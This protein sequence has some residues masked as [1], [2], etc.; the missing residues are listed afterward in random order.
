MS[1]RASALVRRWVALYTRGLTPDVREA[2][3]EEIEADL[4]SQTEDQ[5]RSGALSG[6]GSTAI[7]SRLVRGLWADITW[8]L[9]QRRTPPQPAPARSH[10]LGSV[11]A[12]TCAIAGGAGLFAISILFILFAS[13]DGPPWAFLRD[14]PAADLVNFTGKASLVL[15]ALAIW[16][17]TF[18]FSEQVSPS[19]AVLGSIGGAAGVI[20][21]TGGYLA[22]LVLPIGSSVLVLAM[23]RLGVLPRAVA[24]AHGAAAALY[25]VIA[26]AA[27]LDQSFRD[28]WI[29]LLVSLAL[30]YPL[31]WIAIGVALLRGVPATIDPTAASGPAVMDAPIEEAPQGIRIGGP[32]FAREWLIANVLAFAAGAAIGGG[33]LRALSEPYYGVLMSATDAAVIQA[34]SAGIAGVLL[35]GVIGVSQ[36][37]VLRR[38]VRA[39]WWALGTCLGWGLAAA[40]LAFNAGGS[41]STIGPDDGPVDPLLSNLVA[42]PLAFVLFSLVSWLILRRAFVGTGWWPIVN[43]GAALVGLG[44]GFAVAKSLPWLAPTQFPSAYALGIVGL[45]AGPIYGAVTWVYLSALRRR[46]VGDQDAQPAE[47]AVW[48]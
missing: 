32:E 30:A 34:R 40:L 41:T 12:A 13:A 35:G 19:V 37:V 29:G 9:D 44:V 48:T 10:P 14:F 2:R 23:S 36:W 33:V 18:R 38:R 45:V 43:V 7:L 28:S 5:R 42:L 27:F 39:S 46:A 15:V 16:W 47:A 25:I 20:A 6:A 3:R 17:L 11:V 21:A 31:T 4:W 1:R 24:V 8:R 22:L 26:G